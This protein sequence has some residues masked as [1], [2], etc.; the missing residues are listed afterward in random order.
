MNNTNKT[1]MVVVAVV[2]GLSIYLFTKSGATG[3][4]SG[5]RDG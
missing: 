3:K 2:A 1:N 4:R 5:L